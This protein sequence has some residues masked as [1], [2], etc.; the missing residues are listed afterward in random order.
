[1]Q[2][3]SKMISINDF[4]NKLG[5]FI[6]IV[7][8][9]NLNNTKISNIQTDSR[10][11][12]C[13]SVFVCISGFTVDGHN[14]AEQV[15]EQGAKLLITEKLLEIDVAQIVV[16]NSREACA[17][18]AKILFDNP[19][20]GFL[21]IGITGTNGK[22]STAV[23]TENVLRNAGYKTGLI[24]TLGYSI[25]G[26]DFKSERTTPDIIDLNRIFIRMR[27]EEI[28]VAVMEVSSH[29][30]DLHRV[31]GL[32]FDVG[33]FTNLSPEH[34][35]FHK[36][37]ESYKKAKFKLFR[38]FNLKYAI[39][40][41]GD[42]VGDELASN[43]DYEVK[44][45]S[46]DENIKIIEKSLV[47]TTFEFNESNEK[48]K[49]PFI[50]N[51]NVLNAAMAISVAKYIN[52]ELTIDEV[53]KYISKSRIPGRLESVDNEYGIGVFVDYA[54]TPDA[55]RNVLQSLSK[56]KEGRII[57][58]FG[59]GGDRDKLKRPL[60][61]SESLNYSDLT[62]VTTD[63]PRSED[64]AK[65]IL[66]IVSDFDPNDN[67]WINTDRSTAIK[68]AINLAKSGD[69]VL[70]AGKGHETYQ[71]IN[72][73]K[74]HFDDREEARKSLSSLNFKS[75]DRAMVTQKLSIPIDLLQ[76]QF[77]LNDL[78]SPKSINID[79]ITTDSRNLP[80]D[81]LFVA[82]KGEK[83]DG[84][85]FVEA[86]TSEEKCYAITSNSDMRSEKTI[87]YPDTTKA[88][89]KLASK[90]R[91][92]FATD[93][94]GITGSYG[95]TTTKE[96]LFNILSQNG[97]V[98]K[99]YKNENNQIGVPKTIFALTPKTDYLILEMGTNHFG[100]IDAIA[101]TGKPDIG[102]ITSIGD[103]HLEFLVNK[104]GVFREKSALFKHVKKIG[105]ANSEYKS[106]ADLANVETV[107]FSDES[108]YKLI[109]KNELLNATEFELDG[110]AYSIN[111]PISFY[112]LNASLA[113]KTAQFLKLS[114]E[115]ISKGLAVVIDQGDRMKVIKKDNFIIV[116]DC[117]NAGPESMKAGIKYW[118]RN[119]LDYKHVA[120]IGD[121]LELGES[122]AELHKEIG[123]ILTEQERLN[124]IAVGEL[125]KY[126]N[127]NKHFNNID[128][129]LEN[130]IPEQ[131]KAVYFVKASHGI[132][133]EKFVE[134]L[135]Q[136]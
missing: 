37:M 73:I 110:T 25:N 24:G 1:M 98:L 117:Y 2:G 112:A 44:R 61:L 121:M 26:V 77:I 94:V 89:Q 78:N 133:L 19:T 6:E 95:K 14:F 131:E 136:N 4:K 93:V 115:Q 107:G 52:P 50:G 70:I 101:E 88:Y 18:S 62:I 103:V 124:S 42:D 134:K 39:I 109:I 92:L 130:F 122:S 35:D 57:T 102:I 34:L 32:E 17:F 38:N 82:L 40:N 87:Y 116:A 27:S 65:I 72:G 15:V 97:N 113:I 114:D 28:E 5:Q 3:C 108:N 132:K 22:T 21:L 127:I 51:Y 84:N 33:V 85:K 66:D 55:L 99:S 59:A 125:S 83:F 135:L 48:Y 86:V 68:T 79:Y 76:I 104:E 43:L 129:L 58:V 111:S 74:N 123:E 47:T 46:L 23:I 106:F 49:I 31:T 36:D 10:K 96:I 120:V 67:F 100:E 16:S 45:V 8:S 71:E 128:E 53:N 118:Q 7:E 12:N 69:I 126:Y 90:Y 64:P 81:S 11:V 54:H 105:F 20:K 41:V 13:E 30:L 80:K 60:M 75:N 9:Q 63:N 91:S 29:A 56:I 119:W